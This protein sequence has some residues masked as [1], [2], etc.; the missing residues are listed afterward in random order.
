VGQA[1]REDRDGHEG[2]YTP[3]DLLGPRGDPLSGE[4]VVPAEEPVG[5]VPQQGPLLN[6]GLDLL[7]RGLHL[8]ELDALLQ[9]GGHL[10]VP[11]P[12]LLQELVELG[13]I[14][15]RHPALQPLLYLLA[16]FRVQPHAPMLP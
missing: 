6:L 15:L 4:L 9:E 11:H 12:K 2:R 3:E 13:L 5:Q 16:D 8:L 14:G 10:G 1:P 7:L